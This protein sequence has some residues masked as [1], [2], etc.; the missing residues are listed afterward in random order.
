MPQVKT[1]SRRAPLVLVCMIEFLER[2]AFCCVFSLF[3][4]YVPQGHVISEGEA[5]SLYGI[6]IGLSYFAQL[7]GGMLLDR[8]FSKRESVILGI[9]LM[10]LGYGFLAT[11]PEHVRWGLGFLVLGSGPFKSGIISMAGNLYLKK[12]KNERAFQWFYFAI[13][14]GAVIGPI[15]GSAVFSRYGWKAACWLS[16]FSLL[17]GLILSMI[18]GR[19]SLGPVP[20]VASEPSLQGSPRRAYK[21]LTL[22]VGMCAACLLFWVGY[23][24]TGT[25]L[26]YFARDQVDRTLGGRL[27]PGLAPSAFLSLPGFLFLVLSPFLLI[28]FRLLR[29]VRIELSTP[30]KLITGL[31]L[32]ASTMAFLA[33]A[34]QRAGASGQV[35]VVWLLCAYTLLTLAE[36]CLEPIGL[37]LISRL[38]PARQFPLYVGAW[39]GVVALG[40]TLAGEVGRLWNHWPHATFFTFLSAL[41]L[42]GAAILAALRSPLRQAIRESQFNQEAANG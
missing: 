16:A 38:V 27:N 34:A 4:L 15:I 25:T 10:T 23:H 21:E 1:L 41:S 26:T 18:L 30:G 35:G 22:F 9:G 2:F 36:L 20:P 19:E 31:L 14:G 24:Q 11:Q 32:G 39:Y 33:F 40:G 13:N 3:V 7:P 29:Q 8:L 37:S 42:A 6:F 12:E 5:T 17:L 28:V